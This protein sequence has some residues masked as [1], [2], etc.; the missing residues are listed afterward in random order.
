[1]SA[2]LKQLM[3]LAGE[4]F[5]RESYAQLLDR[6]PD[7]D[8]LATYCRHLS[9][10]HAKAGIILAIA[11]SEEGQ[12]KSA[13][14]RSQVLQLRVLNFI[15]RIRNG[16]TAAKWTP[17]SS[18]ESVACVMERNPERPPA[19]AEY[20][21]SRALALPNN[22]DHN[23]EQ[24]RQLIRANDVIVAYELFL[25]RSPTAAE[26]KVAQDHYTNVE[27]LLLGLSGTDEFRGLNSD[28]ISDETDI[29]RYN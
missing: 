24:L 21:A 29:Q 17:A 10:G 6:A 27:E 1:M 3:N 8:G 20:T 13:L 19:V 5:V 2:N 26:L 4:D 23:T 25:E 16:R 7:P 12:K 15:A 14:S 18:D 28:L 9:S 11:A 22:T